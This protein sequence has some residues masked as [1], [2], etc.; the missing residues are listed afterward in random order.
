VASIDEG[1]KLRSAGIKKPVLILGLILKEDIEPLFEYN[2]F[3]L[4][5]LM[6]WR[7]HLI[8]WLEN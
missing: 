3:P 4:F 5:A 7:R 6:N 8:P 2:L 1:I